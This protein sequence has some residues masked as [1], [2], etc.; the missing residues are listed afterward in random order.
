MPDT[1]GFPRLAAAPFLAG[2][3]ASQTPDVPLDL[4]WYVIFRGRQVGVVRGW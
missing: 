4:R 3:Q 2:P 1:G